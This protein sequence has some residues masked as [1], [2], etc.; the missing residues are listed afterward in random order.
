MKIN[1]PINKKINSLTNKFI[2]QKI[3]ISA[4]FA[5]ILLPG[6]AVY[7]NECIPIGS[8]TMEE[9]TNK[10]PFVCFN[11]D[12]HNENAGLEDDCAICHHVYEDGK[13]IEDE[14]S[15]DFSCSECH[16][17]E[18]ASIQF[19]LIS[20]FHKRCRGCHLNE[21]KGPVTCGE[22]HGKTK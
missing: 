15:E 8:E 11:H 16:W 7:S 21:K 14:S 2:I 17:K 4:C 18:G 12:T 22:C 13:L 10:R 19:D 5:I 1:T 20:K 9:N 3:I 6:T